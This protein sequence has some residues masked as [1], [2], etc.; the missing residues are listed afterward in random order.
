MSG[1]R[2]QALVG[3]DR[4]PGTI[5]KVDV[6]E[7]LGDFWLVPEWFEFPELKVRKPVRIISLMNIQHQDMPNS[8]FPRFVLNVPVSKDV[9]DGRRSPQAHKYIVIEAPDISLPLLDNPN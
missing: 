4:G 7:H 3:F 2:Y 8:D 6:I 1:T 5:Y 9:F